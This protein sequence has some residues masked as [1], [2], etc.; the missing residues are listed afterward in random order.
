MSQNGRTPRENG[1]TSGG[2]WQFLTLELARNTGFGRHHHD[3]H[4]L[5]VVERGVVGLATP[6]TVWAVPRAVGVWLPGES[7][8]QP[9][10]SAE[11]HEERD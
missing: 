6:D 10:L 7:V 9:A 3:E 8:L 1:A 4:Q 11:D 5:V 2:R